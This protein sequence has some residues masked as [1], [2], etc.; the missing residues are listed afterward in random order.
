MNLGRAMCVE[1]V[2]VFVRPYVYPERTSLYSLYP[3]V[4]RHLPSAIVI[5]QRLFY[6]VYNLQI[7]AGI[8]VPA[9][10]FI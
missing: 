5:R 4:V 2:C 1:C 10:S 6:Y 7:H 3:F 9:I 8:K